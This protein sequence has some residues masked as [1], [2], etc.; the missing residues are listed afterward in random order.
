[1]TLTLITITGTFVQPDGTDP[2]TGKVTATL[3]EAIQN[4]TT[5]IEPQ[6]RVGVLNSAGQLVN[7]AG[8]AFQLYANDDAATVPPGSTYE[9][10]VEIENAPLRDGSVT[11]PHTAAAG[12]ID[13]TVLLP[14]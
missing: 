4:G 11:V 2:L 7:E 1:M 14:L 12:T 5:T 10:V 8:T 3:S 13:L 9:F 6:P